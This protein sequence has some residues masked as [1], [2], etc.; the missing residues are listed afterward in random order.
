ME[1]PHCQTGVHESW[2]MLTHQRTGAYLLAA[3]GEPDVALVFSVM[4][5][6]ACG[7]LVAQL[8]RDDMTLG[9]GEIK[10][11]YPLNV[12]E[13][14]AP[15][16]VPEGLRSDYGEATAI[17]TRSPQ[18]SA[19]LS[20]RIVQEVLNEQGGYQRRNLIDQIQ[21]FIDDP[22]NPSGLKQNIDYLRE[23]GNFAAHPMK[24]TNTGEVLRVDPGEA[25]WAIEVVDG[26]FDFYFVGPARDAD[27]RNEFERRTA[28][29]GRRPPSSS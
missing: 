20:R 27:R 6:P 3:Q 13:R 10:I 9:E 22:K 29:A 18:A 28:E 14:P 19:A 25:E 12:A 15:V 2:E 1:C 5:C 21:D 11:V 24:S 8:R 16:V 26:L 23:I 17:L 7:K 4:E